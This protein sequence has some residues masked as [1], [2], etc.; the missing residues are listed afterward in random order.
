MSFKLESRWSKRG[1]KKCPKCGTPNGHRAV[2]CKNKQ[3]RQIL[4]KAAASAAAAAAGRRG[5][6]SDT[7]DQL[8]GVQL[9]TDLQEQSAKL[10]SVRNVSGA[11]EDRGFVEIRDCVDGAD[12]QLELKTG[13]CYV[14]CEPHT[15]LDGTC[16]HVRVAAATTEMAEALPIEKDVLQRLNATDDEREGIWKH[17]MNSAEDDPLVQKISFDTF[18]VKCYD[19]DPHQLVPYCHVELK[20]P[21][22]FGILYGGR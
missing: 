8:V 15:D 22:R 12:E 17:Q 7:N 9:Q 6:C 21:S 10:Y 2:Q 18:V 3:C 11:R 19:D 1:I 20:L 13:I 4:N 14:D 5:K 16:Q